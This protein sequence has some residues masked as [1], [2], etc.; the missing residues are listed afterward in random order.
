MTGLTTYARTDG[1]A[2]PSLA[3]LMKA[4]VQLRNGYAG[5][6]AIAD[7]AIFHLQGLSDKSADHALMVKYAREVREAMQVAKWNGAK[8]PD[9]FRTA[10]EVC[11]KHW[12][13]A[14]P[15]SAS[16][17]NARAGVALSDYRNAV[18]NADLAAMRVA[19]EQAGIVATL[20]HFSAILG[21]DL[22]NALL[23][24]S[25][26]GTSKYIGTYYASGLMLHLECAGA[27]NINIMLQIVTAGVTEPLVL[28]GEAKGGASRLGKVFGPGP[29]TQYGLAPISQGDIRYPLSRAHYMAQDPGTTPEGKARQSAGLII[30]NAYREAT[31]VYVVANGTCQK[32]VFKHRR[33]V[34]SCL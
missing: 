19:H 6:Q 7:D 4:V 5:L 32:Q 26:I 31:L 24:A 21:E 15:L 23:L 3:G 20:Y 13:Q 2:R 14:T 25:A 28:V 1:S 22:S 30:Q 10:L 12:M 27:Y 8:I 34:L 16:G 18:L 33:K 9:Q 11:A 29:M 17:F